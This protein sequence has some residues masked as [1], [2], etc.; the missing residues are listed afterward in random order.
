M[1]DSEVSSVAPAWFTIAALGALLWELAGCALYLMRMTVDPAT[2]PA[3][4]LPIY[5]ATPQWTLAAFAIAVWVG[6]IGSVLLLLRRRQAEWLLLASLLAVLVQNSVY[7]VDAEMRNLVAS[8]Q[9]LLPFVILIVCYG[10]WMLARRARK[11]G[12]LR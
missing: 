10:I 9:L 3:D 7:V 11:A 12:W 6:L 1:D 4:Q 2:L 5:E 8:E